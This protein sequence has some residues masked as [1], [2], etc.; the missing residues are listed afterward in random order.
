MQHG[1]L[2]PYLIGLYNHFLTV[3]LS[4]RRLNLSFV[5]TLSAL[6]EYSYVHFMTTWPVLSEQCAPVR[7]KER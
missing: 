6:S 7:Y 4:F 3:L 5:S 1:A 2:S